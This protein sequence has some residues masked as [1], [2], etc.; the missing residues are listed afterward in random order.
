M[1]TGR[2]DAGPRAGHAAPAARP[3]HKLLAAARAAASRDTLWTTALTA[4]AAYVTRVR[5]V[6]GAPLEAEILRVDAERAG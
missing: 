6:A 4:D 2:R 1:P 3:P 5:Q